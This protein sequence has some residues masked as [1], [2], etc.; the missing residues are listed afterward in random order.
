MADKPSGN[1]GVQRFQA[2]FTN[3]TEAHGRYAERGVSEKGKKEGQARTVN[4]GLLYEAWAE[5]LTGKGHGVGA[6]PLL[7]DNTC[8]FAAIDVDQYPLDLYEL[9]HRIV[10]MDLPLVVC[11]SKS[12]GAHL[13]VFFAEPV[14]AT[15]VVQRMAIWAAALGYGTSEIFPKQTY[16]ATIRDIGNWINL[17][18]YN[19]NNTNRYAVHNGR[20]LSA[21]EFL[22]YA[23]SKKQTQEQFVSARKMETQAPKKNL[24]LFEEAPPCLRHLAANGGFPDGTRNNGMYDIAVYLRKRF[25]DAW[26][27]KLQTYN[28]EMCDP[29]LTLAEVQDIAKSVRRKNYQYMCNQAPIKAYCNKKACYGQ[30]FGVGQTFD[31]ERSC[32]IGHVTKLEGEPVIW[33]LEIDG[34]RMECLTGDWQDQAKFNKMCAERISRIPGVMPQNRWL[35]YMD[36]KIKACDTIASPEEASHEGQ[37]WLLVEQFIAGKVQATSKDELLVNKPW[38]DDGKVYFRSRALLE[39]LDNHRLRYKSEHHVWQML[40]KK[41]AD[42]IFMNLKGKGT[43]VWFVPLPQLPDEKPV[44]NK[45]DDKIPF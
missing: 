41:G 21:R 30:M 1:T 17:P 29:P 3:Y 45:I 11:R 23:E 36:E 38:K 34:V 14:P 2:L 42:K 4:G 12:G 6:I 33:I 37:F 13:Y 5:H 22:D 8:L 18:Y 44:Q 31:G 35:K 16:R 15:V 26:E 39:Y 28:V 25:P 32:E 40:R 19:M 43:N 24:N 10:T 20:N 27:D 7:D 9:E